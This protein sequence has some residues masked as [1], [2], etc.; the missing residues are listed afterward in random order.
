MSVSPSAP[1]AIPVRQPRKN[2]QVVIGSNSL[3]MLSLALKYEKP[4]TS[5]QIPRSRMSSASMAMR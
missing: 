1:L 5:V 2:H 3:R 4:D